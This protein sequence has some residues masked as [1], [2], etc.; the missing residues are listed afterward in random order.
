[1]FKSARIK[2]TTYYLVIIMAISLSFSAFIYQ[3]VNVEFQRRLDVIENRIEVERP[4][5]PRMLGPVHDIFLQDLNLAR[6][7]I[8]LLL[9][10]A[11]GTIL[12]L[13]AAAGYY[14]AGKT[15]QPI[16]ATLE[17]QKR[18]VADASHELKTPLTALQTSIEVAL[19]D[20]KLNLKNAKEILKESLSDIGNLTSLSN[21]LLA[22]ARMQSNGHSFNFEEVE[23]NRL[24]NESVKKFIPLAKKKGVSL[25][26]STDKAG[27]NSKKEKLKVDKESFTK[28]ITILIDNAIKYTQKG[29]EVNVSVKKSKKWLAIKV[30]DTGVGISK[31]DLPHIFERFYQADSSRTKSKT[32]GFGLGLSI[33]KKI[34]EFHKGN[35]KV[36]SKLGKGSTFIV[37]L[38]QG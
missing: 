24:I 10:Y 38:P 6:K 11:N 12:V 17:E 4:F 35:I 23:V 31:A 2:L 14:L 33:A 3:S 18:F 34:V 8:L 37:K 5:G 22:L 25:N 27:L 1:M 28:L 16:E 29:G 26:L 30:K 20:K 15:L 19:R 21:N 32:D 36:E 7:R 13:S 9:F